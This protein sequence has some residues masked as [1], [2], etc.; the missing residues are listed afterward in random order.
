MGKE[1]KCTNPDGGG[2]KCPVQ[3]LALC[4]RG[5]DMECYG[6]CIPIPNSYHRATNMFH[7]WLSEN[8]ENATELYVRKNFSFYD[9]RIFIN[10]AAESNTLEGGK[11]IF[12]VN[13]QLRIYVQFEY[14]FRNNINPLDEQRMVV[15]S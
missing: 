5:K 14:E 8:I 1:C 15:L 12:D 7:Q 3:H 2:T 6:E 10:R 13:N 11:V 4:I 9:E